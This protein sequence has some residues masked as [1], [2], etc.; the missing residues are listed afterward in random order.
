MN[1]DECGFLYKDMQRKS[2]NKR[3]FETFIFYFTPSLIP[4]LS[5]IIA[6]LGDILDNITCQDFISIYELL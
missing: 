4:T 1:S 6:L 3:W 2:N 5:H